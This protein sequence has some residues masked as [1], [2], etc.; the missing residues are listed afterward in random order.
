M[1]TPTYFENAAAFR[2]WFEAHADTATELLVGF[3]KVDSGRPSM[4]WSQS[5]DEAL[6]FGW[7]DGVRKRIDDA[8]YTIRFSPRKPTS[9]WS[10]INIAKVA[11]LQAEG[12]MTAAGA[13]AFSHRKEAKSRIYAFEQEAT[14]ELSAQELKTFKREKVAWKYFEASPPGYRKTLLHWVTTAKR[15]ETR[16]SRLKTLIEACA[17]GK[18]LR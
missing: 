3:H 5:V 15:E 17:I 4:T 16:V 11:S 8:A 7:I 1:T 13:K 14:A 6:C 2:R 10:A 12:K 18:R 9:I